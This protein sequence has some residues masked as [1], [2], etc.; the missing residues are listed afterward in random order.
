MKPSGAKGILMALTAVVLV[1]GGV[2]FG[3]AS[4]RGPAETADSG[5]ASPSITVQPAAQAPQAAS[6]SLP[7]AVSAVETVSA[8]ATAS[9][10][11]AKA[12]APSAQPQAVPSTPVAA[13]TA[14]APTSTLP[15]QTALGDYFKSLTDANSAVYV[16]KPGD[17][18]T[19]IA[20]Q[21]GVTPGLVGAANAVKG[22][23]I[24]PGQKLRIPRAKLSVLVEKSTNT[25][26]LKADASVVRSYRIATGKDRSTPEGTFKIINHLKNP[27]WYYEGKVIP[28]DSPDNPLGTRWMGFDKEGYG[29]HGTTRPD[30]IGQFATLGCVRMLNEDIESLFEL[31]PVGTEVT[32]IA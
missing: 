13:S 3:R 27:T 2:W 26:H 15:G 21:Y 19:R 8:T 10:S 5:S 24:F 12:A 16:V 6:A 11:P 25:L 23:R 22:D 7:V 1:V 4:V 28:P 30:E 20:K 9:A 18:L 32:I 14:S 17:N 29:L 31:L